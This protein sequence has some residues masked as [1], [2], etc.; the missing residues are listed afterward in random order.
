[1]EDYEAIPP[2]LIGRAVARALEME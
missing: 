1:G 2:E